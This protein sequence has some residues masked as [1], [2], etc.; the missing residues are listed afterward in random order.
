MPK[1]LS[2]EW[3][4]EMRVAARHW[5]DSNNAGSISGVNLCV[6]EVVASSDGFEALYYITIGNGLLDV[7]SG[8]A[9]D[10]DVTITQD[11]ETAAALHRGDM[12]ARQAFIDGRLKVS[13]KVALV[14]QHAETFAMLSNIFAELRAH[15]T[16]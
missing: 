15:T 7:R 11:Y 3:L 5:N 10:P 9:P 12:S 13:G 2:T 1:F 6:Q 16:F 14:T 8:N 4:E